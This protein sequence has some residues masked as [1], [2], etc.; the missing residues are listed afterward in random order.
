MLLAQ[1]I[2]CR[3]RCLNEQ[4]CSRY[5]HSGTTETHTRPRP[6]GIHQ[7]Q[8]GGGRGRGGRHHVE[9]ETE[10]AGDAQDV[11]DPQVDEVAQLRQRRRRHLRQRQLGQLRVLRQESGRGRLARR[12]DRLL[13]QPGLRGGLQ[14]MAR[15]L[16]QVRE[17]WCA[18]INHVEGRGMNDRERNLFTHT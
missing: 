16:D 13:L 2:S 1:H 4:D 7:G 8:G 15:R 3:D 11:G 12:P 6:R 17:R 5:R 9:A 18:I 14:T 10:A